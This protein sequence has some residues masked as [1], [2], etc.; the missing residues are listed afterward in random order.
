MSFT[1][2]TSYLFYYAWVPTMCM[3]GFTPLK[4]RTEKVPD[5]GL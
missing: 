2:E 5:G 4:G 3:A 1:F